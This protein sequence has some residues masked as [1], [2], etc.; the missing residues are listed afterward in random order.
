MFLC[1]FACIAYKDSS[2]VVNRLR[3]FGNRSTAT[4]YMLTNRLWPR[5]WNGSIKLGFYAGLIFLPRA[6]ETDIGEV[7]V[8]Q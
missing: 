4:S 2:V 3:T 7:I 6:D 8:K 1:V 5:F